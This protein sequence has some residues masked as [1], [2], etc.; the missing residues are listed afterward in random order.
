[1]LAFGGLP[2][3]RAGALGLIAVFCDHLGFGQIFDPLIVSI[4][5][6]LARAEFFYCLFGRGWRFHSASL[7]QNASFDITFFDSL[8]TVSNYRPIM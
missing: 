3:G 5:F 7:L 2:A 4:R 6:I 8:A 1:M